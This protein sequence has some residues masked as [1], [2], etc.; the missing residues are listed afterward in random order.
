MGLLVGH[1]LSELVEDTTPQLGGNLDVNGHNIGGV[2][3]TELSYISGV[4]SG[5]QGQL[6][7]L[8]GASHTQGTDQG[9]DT[10]GANAVTAA[11]AKTA[12][13]HSQVTTGNPHSL[14]S[15]DVGAD[16]AGTATSLVGTHESTYNHSNYDTAYGWGDHA[17][18]YASTTHKDS[19]DPE[20]GSDAIDTAA[21][22]ELAS[23]QAA[24]VGT[25]HS[26]ARADHQHQIQHSIADNHIVTVAANGLEGR[27]YSEVKTDLSLNNVTNDAQI[28]K[29]ASSTDDTLPKWKGTSGDELEDSSVTESGAADAV[30]KKHSQNT[31]TGTTNGSFQ[32]NSGGQTSG[33]G[34]SSFQCGRYNEQSGSNNTQFGSNNTQ[35]GYFSFNNIQSGY[36]NNQSGYNN[37]QSGDNNDQSG[38]NNEQSGDNGL[39]FGH[40]TSDEYAE[41]TAWDMAF[42]HG[43]G[44]FAADGDAQNM[45]FVVRKEET[46]SS[47]TWRSLLIDASS[48]LVL[49]VD[50]AWTFKASVIGMTAGCAK[51]LSYTI[52]G[53]I[54]NDG[55]TCT[56]HTATVT[57][58]HED[59]SD[60]DC[61]VVTDTNDDLQIQVRDSTSGG[62]TVRWVASVDVIQ[63]KYAAA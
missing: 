44:R 46:H 22:S 12:Y 2:T 27:S 26:L 19:H 56:V 45:R 20:D 25:S 15:T 6:N 21:P 7:T 55:G 13:T 35:S 38:Y 41:D 10:G 58:I 31:D 29:A 50:S 62:D 4:T 28:K 17:G 59:D 53:C 18:L 9:L 14:D 36:Y 40:H 23:V 32:V 33:P 11:E 24:A 3:P 43:G 52:E 61:Q 48:R 34:T 49:P 8:S 1:W 60:F 51:V 54:E 30:S 39:Q 5:I 57:T 37:N 63:V 42:T 47:D 16:A